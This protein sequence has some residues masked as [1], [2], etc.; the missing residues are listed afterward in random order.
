MSEIPDYIYL[1]WYG[2]GEPDGSIPIHDEVTWCVD[3]IFTQDIQY[4]KAELSVLKIKDLQ[5]QLKEAEEVIDAA[6]KIVNYKKPDDEH[7]HSAVDFSEKYSEFS[8]LVAQYK[9]KKDG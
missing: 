9:E 3:R 2:D 8:E 5:Q 4:V 1:Q 6:E 7:S